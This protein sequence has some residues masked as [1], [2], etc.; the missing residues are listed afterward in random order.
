MT[1]TTSII[2]II[3]TGNGKDRIMVIIKMAV[4]VASVVCCAVCSHMCFSFNEA[5]DL[6]PIA[7]KILTA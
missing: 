2:I 6:P 4:I 3:I 5:C 7:V 1:H